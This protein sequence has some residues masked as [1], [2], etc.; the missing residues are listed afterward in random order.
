MRHDL[1]H[2]LLRNCG[3]ANCVPESVGCETQPIDR[4]CYTF[5]DVSEVHRYKLATSAVGESCH[6]ACLRN[7]QLRARRRSDEFANQ[8]VRKSN[9]VRHMSI[10]IL[11]AVNRN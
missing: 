1:R 10:P 11:E 6:G 2:S 3:N 4:R 7:C 5:A 8:V 9:K